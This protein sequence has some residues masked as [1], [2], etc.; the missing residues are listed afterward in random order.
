MAP[1]MGTPGF[2][3]SGDV[4]EPSLSDSQSTGQPLD[5]QH[6]HWADGMIADIV[7]KDIQDVGRA[8]KLASFE[9]PRKLVLDADPWTPESGLVTE[10]L[11]I[12]RH[13]MRPKFLKDI[14]EMYGIQKRA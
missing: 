7:L 13:N 11:K 14:E 9:I 1:I 3:K 12:K 6:I 2:T 5:T 8:K 10:A 4:E